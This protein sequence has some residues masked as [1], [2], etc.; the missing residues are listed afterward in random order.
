M[1]ALGWFFGNILGA[2][3]NVFRALSNPGA[4][5]NWSDG[6]A[7][8]RFAYYGGSVEL[9]FVY[10]VTFLLVFAIGIW[11]RSFLWG[12]T[13]GME[14][15][16]NVVGRA[17]AWIGLIMV[18]QQVVIIML[19][20]FFAQVNLGIGFGDTF[21]RPVSWW[22]EEL[23]FYN[24]I[25]VCLCC[26]YTFVQKGHVRVDLVYAAIGYR[27]KRIVDMIGSV[28]FM[29]SFGVIAWVYCWFFMW[30]HLIVPKVS[31]SDTLDR[32]LTKSR[33]FRWNVETIGPSPNGFDAYFL[34]KVLMVV[35]C[36]MILMQAAAFFYRSFLE[37]TEG[38][39]A[40]DKHLDLDVLDDGADPALQGGH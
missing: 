20:R 17:A 19:Q 40:E 23:K 27:A 11:S 21:V 22:S 1:D 14:G 13:L 38:E 35:F 32:M 31:A 26:A 6:E 12:V 37:L 5:L 16:S 33:A 18:L 8:M 3:V 30:R 28:V 34:F 9:F 25:I 7:V 15:V 4:W 2:F 36:G 39:E 24:A 10:F 29:M